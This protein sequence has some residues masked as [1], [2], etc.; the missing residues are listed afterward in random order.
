MRASA[1][2]GALLIAPAWAGVVEGRGSAAPEVE[3]RTFG[4]I[5]Q[6]DVLAGVAGFNQKIYQATT[7]PK[8][9]LKCNAFNTILRR[10]W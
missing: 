7:S 1:V 2:L 9:W 4:E 3:K 5:L 8:Q 6:T 10:E